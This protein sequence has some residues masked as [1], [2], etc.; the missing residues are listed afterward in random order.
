MQGL[1]LSDL[2]KQSPFKESNSRLA[3]QE[4]F[5]PGAVPEYFLQYFK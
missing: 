4:V 3:C 5:L 1:C 2:M